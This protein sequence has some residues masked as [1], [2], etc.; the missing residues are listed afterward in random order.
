MRY[1]PKKRKS[2]GLVLAGGGAKGL[3]HIGVLK[4]LERA[5][6][7]VDYIMGVSMGAIVGAMYAYHQDAATVEKIISEYIFSE[8][9]K[10]VKFPDVEDPAITES[11]WGHFTKRLKATVVIN[12][13]AY[14]ISIE[15]NVQLVE[16]VNTFLDPVSTFEE[17]KIPFGC[18]STDL[19]QGE[20]HFANKGDLKQA[21]VAS[22]SIPGFLPPIVKEDALLVDG[23]VANNIPVN[24]MREIYKPDVLIASAFPTKLDKRTHYDSIYDIAI[25][26]ASINYQHYQE[27]L[28]DNA[29]VV[30]ISQVDR[31]GWQ[32]FTKVKELIGIGER[33]TQA[34]I[35]KIKLKIGNKKGLKQRLT[36]LMG[37]R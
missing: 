20:Y 12:L 33:D 1:F 7:P 21:V 5:D 27:L 35:E 18:I 11:F 31:Y 37:G 24:L 16:A 14:K 2:V 28:L 29:D 4:E 36:Q 9:F 3:A 25:R 23:A 22:A 6:I 10:R 26:S 30:I 8:Q 15:E 13:A 32:E 19:V 17:L 34:L